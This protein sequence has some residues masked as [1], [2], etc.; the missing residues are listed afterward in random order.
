MTT[1]GDKIRRL[2]IAHPNLVL[3]ILEEFSSLDLYNAFEKGVQA[4]D[5]ETPG[6]IKKPFFNELGGSYYRAYVITPRITPSTG[7]TYRAYSVARRIDNALYLFLLQKTFSDKTEQALDSKFVD[8]I[9]RSYKDNEFINEGNGLKDRP[10]GS[11]DDVWSDGFVNI[12]FEENFGFKKGQ[13]EDDNL[14][15]FKSQLEDANLW[16][17]N[18]SDLV[19]YSM[20]TKSELWST[21]PFWDL[22]LKRNAIYGFE[23][24][25]KQILLKVKQVLEDKI[26]G[27]APVGYQF[28][29]VEKVLNLWERNPLND[30]YGSSYEHLKNFANYDWDKLPAEVN[31]RIHVPS[32][33]DP[34]MAIPDN[35]ELLSVL[36]K[37]G[38]L[39]GDVNT[40]KFPE[41]TLQDIIGPTTRFLSDVKYNKTYVVDTS[42][43]S[44]G[45]A[46]L[47]NRRFIEYIKSVLEGF[48][49]SI[50]QQAVSSLFA[51]AVGTVTDTNGR[52]AWEEAWQLMAVMQENIERQTFVENYD[53]DRTSD[54]E[55][56]DLRKE[57]EKERE[58]DLEDRGNSDGDPEEPEESPDAEERI[59]G[60]QKFFKQCA[61][62]LNALRLKQLYQEELVERF[63]KTRN[64]S[65]AVEITNHLFDQRLY[66]IDNSYSETVS[67]ML[68]P[69]NSDSIE[70]HQFPSRIFTYLTPVVRLFKITNRG[71][72]KEQTEF[73][74]SPTSDINRN[75]NFKNSTVFSGTQFD[76]GEGAGLKDFSFEFNGTN[77]AEARNDIEATMTLYFQSFTDFL[78]ER[79]SYNG[80]TYRF[81]DLI[82]QPVEED[83]KEKKIH[84]NHYD[85]TFYKILVQ[86]GYSKPDNFD[87]VFG[88]DDVVLGE[89]FE[90]STLSKVLDNAKEFYYLCMVDHDITLNP[91]S[92]VII[93]INYRAYVETALKSNYFDAL[94]TREIINRRIINEQTLNEIL[95]SGKCTT[96]QIQEL[97]L[98]FQAE[99]QTLRNSSLKSIIKRLYYRNKIFTVRVP[100]NEA[101]FF[102][103]FGYFNNPRFQFTNFDSDSD[104]EPSKQLDP[105]VVDFIMKNNLSSLDD[106]D[107]TDKLD[108][109]IQ[110][111][112]FADLLHTVCDVL[113]NGEEFY[114]DFDGAR[115][116][117]A[118]FHFNP[119]GQVS[120]F[121]DILNIGEIPISVDYFLDWFVTNVVSQGNAR[122]SFP[123][124]IFI[125]N[126][127]N[128]L[129]SQSLL[130]TC[131]NRDVEKTFRFQTA[132][133]LKVNDSKEH[134]F[135]N[136]CVFNP[137]EPDK[138]ESKVE[139]AVFYD[140]MHQNA[141]N[142]EIENRFNYCL[143][144]TVGS[145]L[146]KQGA[147]D[148]EMD[149]YRGIDHFEIGSNRGMIK[150]ISFSKSD[151][152][153]VRE[154]RFFSQGTDGLLQLA[155]VYV[156]T[157]EMFGNVFYY[158]G[159]TI[160]INPFGMGGTILGSPTKG[161]STGDASYANKLGF[162]GYHTITNVKSTI[163]NGQF[164]T[165][166][167]AQWY[168][169]GDGADNYNVA[170]R[171][172]TLTESDDL[173]E[174]DVARTADYCNSVIVGAQ[175]NL[176][177]LQKG[178]RLDSLADLRGPDAADDSELPPL[179]L[180]EDMGTIME[181]QEEI[182]L[183]ILE[184]RINTNPPEEDRIRDIDETKNKTFN[185]W[186]EIVDD[187]VPAGVNEGEVFGYLQCY[188]GNGNVMVARISAYAI[189]GVPSSDGTGMKIGYFLE[190][191][192]FTDNGNQGRP[193][194]LT[195]E[196]PFG[197]VDQN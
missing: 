166:I 108:R 33:A 18:F 180:F 192:T 118:N 152:Q 78:R 196:M 159:Q 7:L 53:P 162:G 111:F 92:S 45:F 26:A 184:F 54:S 187:K 194:Y 70:F 82:I 149:F 73:I 1:L 75:S 81:V 102:R 190:A 143:I 134:H 186:N 130:E 161:P 60:R 64:P 106:W 181:T 164:T 49:T 169:S 25:D 84:P 27:S 126:L 11:Y 80:K 133:T 168:Y 119:Y 137:A 90:Y 69:T 189:G 67:N 132:T 9:L 13:K 23:Q 34:Q 31:R 99:E 148:P 151:M 85:P 172:N 57:I 35:T 107:Y 124:L 191:G 3:E 68:N 89:D 182:G 15:S 105:T 28:T 120:N 17:K 91:D 103:E 185:R 131:V 12:V 165:T 116:L 20:K 96:K 47:V 10:I 83:K 153:Y 114:N 37:A 52:T 88:R 16:G 4:S 156:A 56:D 195:E 29:P 5:D 141:E 125:R 122:K 36:R 177:R 135:I 176:A 183:S 113:Y 44:N 129:L 63:N 98:T 95:S 94:A 14:I 65:G 55:I 21:V 154:A 19:A 112:Y 160:Y 24:F 38:T 97:K 32:G 110:F 22:F 71:S 115:F 50:S 178:A 142:L 127:L 173:T 66:M 121:S 139:E 163:S 62:L 59:K 174:V 193:L 8:L 79:V 146:N 147:G 46:S 87:D 6:S 179:N 101:L 175:N 42:R 51:A 72:K 123:I 104:D 167:T 150:N 2:T 58:K 157:I 171:S 155:A 136:E 138:F 100:E 170:G 188:G 48:G 145:D 76:K 74:F 30:I 109:N 144:S 140:L 158:P 117:L 86:V 43:S 40:S 77:P 41:R 39:P 128:N 61:L 93:K 197:F